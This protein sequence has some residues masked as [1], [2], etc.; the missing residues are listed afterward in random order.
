MVVINF[1]LGCI[2]WILGIALIII[3]VV[4]LYFFIIRKE[5]YKEDNEEKEE[6]PIEPPKPV[7]SQDYKDNA[8]ALICLLANEDKADNIILGKR[9][10]RYFVCFKNE[11]FKP[12]FAEWFVTMKLFN[13]GTI[14]EERYYKSF[15][16]TCKEYGAKAEDEKR[17][18]EEAKADTDTNKVSQKEE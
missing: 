8:A 7:I 5:L 1:I 15:N 18:I 14:S 6:K 2:L 3:G 9:E 17:P 13:E 11:Y 12:F 10:N 16:E 4:C